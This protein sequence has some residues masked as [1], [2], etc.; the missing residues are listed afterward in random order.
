M[1][2]IRKAPVHHYL[3]TIRTTALIGVANQPHIAAV[4]RAR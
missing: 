3:H 2:D 4:V 1:A